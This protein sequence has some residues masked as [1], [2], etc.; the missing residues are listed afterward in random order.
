[1]FEVSTFHNVHTCSLDLRRKDN[2]QASP[3]IV[4]H[5]IKDKFATDGSDHLAS[6]IRKSMHKDY[7]IQMSYEK[8]WRCR[9]KAL[10]LAH[11]TPEDSY[12]KLP[13]YLHMQ[14]RNPGTITN[15]AVEDDRFKYGEQML[16]AVALDA[17][18]H[19]F[20]IA[21]AIVDSENHNSW[22][23]FM[24][25]FK[26]MIGDVENLAFILD[27]HESIVRTLEIVFPDAHHGACYH[28]I[29]MNVNYKFKTDVFKNYIYMCAYTYSKLEFHREF[30]NIRTMN[31]AVAQYLEKIGFEK[32]VR[33][34]F[35]G[36]RYNV[37][38]SNWAE[39]F[40]NTTKDARGFPITAVVA[41]LRSKVHPGGTIQT[42]GVVDLQEQTCTCSLFQCMK[43]PC[44]HACAVG[45]QGSIS[46]YALCS[47]YYTTEYWRSTYEGTIM[48]VGDEDDWEL[49]DDI[50][51]MTIRVPVEKQPVRR[52][53]KQKVG[54]IKN[55]RTACNGERVIIP[56]NCGKCGAKGHNR[57][58]C[59]YRG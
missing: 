53:K 21:F 4:A 42:G 27:K 9:E 12:S 31:V 51:N 47:P 6:D 46:M 11:G 37:M 56:R 8:A 39:S 43:F 44:P 48:P 59:T 38:T 49:P 55:N 1:M 3:L 25:K 57:S 35:P 36:V 30:E 17:G 45:Q 14:L 20:P 50:K 24:R 23:Y 52:P 2:R 34:Y 41:F 13:S 58:T 33:S 40:N 26:E 10:H 5:L 28:H 22:T 7:G 18:S 32:R 19:I 15:F 54:R 16:C 29:I